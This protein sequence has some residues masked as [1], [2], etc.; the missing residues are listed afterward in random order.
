MLE[1]TDRARDHTKGAV[2]Q[3]DIAV[4]GMCEWHSIGV[5]VTK[6]LHSIMHSNFNTG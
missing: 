4:M 1:C 5:L 6:L 2:V 3:R